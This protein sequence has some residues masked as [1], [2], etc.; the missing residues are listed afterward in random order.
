MNKLPD[1]QA[2]IQTQGDREVQL[3]LRDTP[4]LF[5]KK[6]LRLILENKQ[7]NARYYEKNGKILPYQII[8]HEIC[9]WDCLYNSFEVCWMVR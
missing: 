4:C 1:L 3:Y 8:L 6:I 7:L 5:L 2:I 9:W